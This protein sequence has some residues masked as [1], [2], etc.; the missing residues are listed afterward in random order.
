MEY[1]ET[2]DDINMEQSERNTRK[3]P[4]ERFHSKTISGP[5]E[6]RAESTGRKDLQLRV[7]QFSVGKRRIN[8]WFRVKRNTSVSA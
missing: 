3:H 6:G 2:L 1:V 8:S 5:L 4:P 7:T